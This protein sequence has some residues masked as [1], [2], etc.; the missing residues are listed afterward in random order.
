MSRAKTHLKRC[1]IDEGLSLP[2]QRSCRPIER[3]KLEKG[4]FFL[5]RQVYLIIGIA[6]WTVEGETLVAG[7]QK[8][9]TGLDGK[10]WSGEWNVVIYD[11]TI[12]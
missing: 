8:E 4:I 1:T 12:C 5:Q 3:R 10:H 6:G 9:Q 11:S 2:P 7:D